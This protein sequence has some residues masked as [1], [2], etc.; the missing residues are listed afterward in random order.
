M[1]KRYSKSIKPRNKTR[2]NSFRKTRR[3]RGGGGGG[4]GCSGA[5][6]GAKTGAGPIGQPRFLGGNNKKTNNKNKKMRG[7][8]FNPLSF[9]NNPFSPL[10]TFGN[11]NGA[12]NYNNV[13][14]G[15]SV[16][17]NR[18]YMNPINKTYHDNNLPLV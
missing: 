3:M 10:T 8:F 5:G 16:I 9:M 12:L 13:L 11:T 7:G 4:C 15:K 6:A 14:N 17:D 18:P 1:K 2:K